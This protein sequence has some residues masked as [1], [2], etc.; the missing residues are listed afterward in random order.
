MKIVKCACSRP[1]H[2]YAVDNGKCPFCNNA[3]NVNETANNSYQEPLSFLNE[4]LAQIDGF[5]NTKNFGNALRLIDEVFEWIPGWEIGEIPKSGEI[6]W[7]KLLAETGCRSDLEM[8]RK[9]KLL[10]SYPAFNNAL[11]YANDDEASVY[12]LVKISEDLIVELLIKV[13]Y[14]SEIDNKRKTGV[15]NTLTEYKKRLEE[16]CKLTQENIAQL[17]KIEKAIHEQAIDCAAVS[18]EYKYVLKA[19]LSEAQFVGNR[20]KNE[21]EKSETTPLESQLD[22]ILSRSNKELTELNQLKSNHP[23]FLEYTRLVNEQKTVSGKINQNKS[24]MDKLNESAEQLVSAI[25]KITN[26]YIEA[27]T[28]MHNGN[29]SRAAALISQARFDEIIKQVLSTVKVDDKSQAEIIKRALST[30]QYEIAKKASSTAKKNEIF[31]W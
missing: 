30:A 28:E 14:A 23:K 21:M 25:E 2:I 24:D 19:L 9:G 29:Y 22:D 26:A 18:G 11:K 3:V 7:R 20:H 5:I 27:R 13:L 12:A 4:K 10:L 16:L 17:D 15:E 31:D 6:H 1:I 8:L